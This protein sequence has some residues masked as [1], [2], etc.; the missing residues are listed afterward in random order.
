VACLAFLQDETVLPELAEFCLT[1]KDFG[2]KESALWAYAFLGGKIN[3]LGSKLRKIEK[4][5]R[6][7]QFLDKL[8]ESSPTEL[9][10][11]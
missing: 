2:V 4:R 11:V 10:F 7:I 8:E 9:W 5:E 1:E 3:E 6:I